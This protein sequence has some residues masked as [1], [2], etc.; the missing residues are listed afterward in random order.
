MKFKNMFKNIIDVIIISFFI[1]LSIKKGGFYK[2]DSLFF[3]LLV[4]FLGSVY[5]LSYYLKNILEKYIKKKEDDIKVKIRKFDVIEILLFLLTLSYLLPIIFNNYSNLSDSIFEMIRYFSIYIIYFIVKKSDNKNMYMNGILIMTLIQCFIGV[6]GLANRYLENILNTFN[7]G[8]LKLNNLSRMSATIQYANIFSLFCVISS[9]YLISKI[10]KYSLEKILSNK[11]KYSLIFLLLVI[12]TSSIILSQSRIILAVFIIYVIFTLASKINI[13]NKTLIICSIIVSVV[14]SNIFMNILNTN[15]IYVY[16]FTILTYIISFILSIIY[17]K[18]LS[19]RLSDKKTDNDIDKKESAYFNK[20][21]SII[22][23]ATKD[24]KLKAICTIVII[25]IYFVLTIVLKVPVKLTSSSNKNDISRNIYKLNANAQN[26]IL[27]RIKPDQEDTR[28]KVNFLVVND[29]LETSQIKSYGYYSNTNDTFEIKYIPK[30][31][32]KYLI[33]N[34]SCQKGSLKITDILVNNDKNYIDYILFPSEILYRIIDFLSGDT[35]FKERIYY[36]EDAIKIITKSYANF[37]IGVGGEG[38]KNIYEQVK[39]ANYSSTEVHNVYLQIFVESGVIGFILFFLI[40]LLS[41]KNSKNNIIKLLLV[42]IY[43]TSFFDLNF[44][45]LIVM[46]TFAILLALL[47]KNEVKAKTVQSNLGKILLNVKY[48]CYYI[49]VISFSIVIFVLVLKANIAYYM[50]I[51]KIDNNEVTFSEIT[52]SVTLKEKRVM[53]DKSE[54]AYRE[55]LLGD[56]KRYLNIINECII[57]DKIQ[58]TDDNILKQE[59]ENVLNNVEEN[60]VNMK[61]NDKYNIDV[62]S[63]YIDTLRVYLK[64]LVNLKFSEDKNIGYEYYLNIIIS[65]IEILENTKSREFA[66]KEYEILYDYL[67]EI[68][69]ELNSNTIQNY[70]L[71]LDKKLCSK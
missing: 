64:D 9:I 19:K 39:I 15:A 26:D 12:Y 63:C 66:F 38:F 27:V 31:D 3:Y 65:N 28:Y 51:P 40:F 18:I 49:L 6:D 54:N 37:F 71:M 46:S 30:S 17:F 60:I 1:I 36:I 43:I 70:M 8:Y 13:N 4:I 7:S 67:K 34:I 16:I 41:L 69:S 62:L 29:K 20:F 11:V 32:F 68:N 56:Y 44:S 5:I 52:S 22:A 33:V 55:S 2:T 47:D 21:K 58:F 61:N 53:L 50:K 57:E 45:Y 25:C 10:K 48:N 24:N 42:I 23:K 59:Y 35:S 14:Y